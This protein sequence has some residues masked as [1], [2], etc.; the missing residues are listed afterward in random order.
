[1]TLLDECIEA[2]GEDAEILMNSEKEKVLDALESSFPFAEWGRI[3][4]DKVS[5]KRKCKYCR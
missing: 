4:W 1:M 3:D 2:L 5:K